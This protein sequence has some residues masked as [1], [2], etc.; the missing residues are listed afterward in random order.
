M[1]YECIEWLKWA[2][3]GFTTIKFSMFQFPTI[4][5]TIGISTGVVATLVVVGFLAVLVCKKIRHQMIRDNYKTQ[6]DMKSDEGTSIAF[7]DIRK[8]HG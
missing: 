7:M 3:V 5:T 1:Q 8:C 2:Q 4:A 6:G